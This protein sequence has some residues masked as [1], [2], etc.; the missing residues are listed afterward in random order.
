MFKKNIKYQQVRPG[1]S[2]KNLQKLA[3]DMKEG[4]QIALSVDIERFTKKDLSFLKHFDHITHLSIR[5]C[6]HKQIEKIQS[7]NNL[8]DLSLLSVKANDYSFLLPMKKL[9]ILDIRLGSSKDFSLLGKLENLKALCFLK[10][11]NLK[12]VSFLSNIINL[13]YFSINSCKN[14]T[15]FP[16]LSNLNK[17]R[18]VHLE[19]MNGLNEIDGISKAPNL[20][21]LIVIQSNSLE[22]NNFN[23][24]IDHV[25]LKKVLPG[26]GTLKSKK[27]RKTCGMFS[28]RTMDGFYGTENENFDLI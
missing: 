14:V 28:E 21:E 7:L 18:R 9:E 26:I 25:T 23:C 16:N 27:Y 1:M 15:S 4:K 19:T 24:F 20:S 11:N 12:D 6:S 5:G 8:I 13:Q 10:I 3:F 22:P 2:E 17:L